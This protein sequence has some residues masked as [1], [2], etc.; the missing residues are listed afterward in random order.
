M[1]TFDHR[2]RCN[3]MGP[4]QELS[5]AKQYTLEAALDVLRDDVKCIEDAISINAA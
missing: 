1:Q 4:F 5:E 3:E 2:E